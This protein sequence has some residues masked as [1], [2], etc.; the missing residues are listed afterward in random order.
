MNAPDRSEF[1][2]RRM[3]GIGGS[4]IAA[5]LGLSP[6][7]TALQLWMEKTGRNTTETEGACVLRLA[8]IRKQP[9]WLLRQC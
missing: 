5:V 2:A 3:A 4:D 1:L 7:K 9:T 8:T 6:Y